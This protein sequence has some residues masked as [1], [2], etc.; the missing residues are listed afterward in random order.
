M[1][2]QNCHTL[3]LSLINLLTTAVQLLDNKSLLKC[4]G[5]SYCF[6]FLFA[7]CSLTRPSGS[8][9]YGKTRKKLPKECNKI[10]IFF[11]YIILP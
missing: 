4:S 3:P 1:H 10:H 9:K 2:T 5:V 6:I 8:P 7:F 11:Y